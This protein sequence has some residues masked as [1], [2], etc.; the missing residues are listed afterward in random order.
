[1]S[2]ASR[3]LNLTP[4]NETSTLARGLLAQLVGLEPRTV[5]GGPERVADGGRHLGV[6][7]TG[8]PRPAVVDAGQDRHRQQVLRVQLVGLANSEH[9]ADFDDGGRRVAR[10]KLTG[11]RQPE[12]APSL[13]PSYFE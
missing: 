11:N 10:Q 7:E 5:R 3:I 2:P 13:L 1:M 12:V 4:G 9:A 6:V 8:A